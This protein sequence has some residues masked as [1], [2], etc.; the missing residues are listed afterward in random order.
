MGVDFDKEWTH[1]VE[2]L[3]GVIGDEKS[4]IVNLTLDSPTSR[5]T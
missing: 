2:S 1:G 3:T 4:L 5:L